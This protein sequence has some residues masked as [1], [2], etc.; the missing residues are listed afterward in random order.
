MAVSKKTDDPSLEVEIIV[1]RLDSISMH[2]RLSHVCSRW[3][4]LVVLFLLRIM[5]LVA[6]FEMMYLPDGETNCE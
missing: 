3:R 5:A 1:H 4:V 6:P 2:A